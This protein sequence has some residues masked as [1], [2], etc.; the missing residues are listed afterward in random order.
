MGVST[1]AI[2]AFG[3][4]LGALEDFPDS[5][6]E[7]GEGG[8]ESFDWQEI[9]TREIGLKRPDHE[10]YKEDWPEFWAAQRDALA[11]FPLTLICHCSYDY[12]MYFLA[13]NGTETRAYRGTP[14]P[15]KRA[16]ITAEQIAALREFCQKWGFEWSEPDWCIFSMWG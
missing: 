2:Q 7:A 11:G 12:P 4:D 8:D 10:N 5:F 3:I 1:D 15:A 9:V 16:D 6:R 13:V 14:K